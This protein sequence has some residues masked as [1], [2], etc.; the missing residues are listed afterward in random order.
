MAGRRSKKSDAPARGRYKPPS[1]Y[2]TASLQIGDSFEFSIE[3]R[4]GVYDWPLHNRIRSSVYQ[5]M[6][7]GGKGKKFRVEQELKH[8]GLFVVVTRIQ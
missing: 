4:A 3:T 8:R 6:R 7:L 2:P 5:Y 1:K